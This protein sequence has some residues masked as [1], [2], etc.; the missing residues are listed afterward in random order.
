M[1]GKIQNHVYMFFLYIFPC[2]CFFIFIFYFLCSGIFNKEGA[3][4]GGE[5]RQVG[6]KSRQRG[7]GR[8]EEGDLGGGRAG[9]PGS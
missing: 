5:G 7:V 2:S 9:C 6:R 4:G 8:S 3:G 1:V